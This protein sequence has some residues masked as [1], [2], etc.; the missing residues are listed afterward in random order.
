M[1]REKLSKTVAKGVATSLNSMLRVEANSTSCV[2]A[3]QPKAPKELA[4]F[5]KDKC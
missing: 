5:R 3:Y 2:I 1:K 4:R